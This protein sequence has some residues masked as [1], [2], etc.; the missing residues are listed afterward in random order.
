M[1]NNKE[2]CYHLPVEKIAAQISPLHLPNPIPA[3]PRLSQENRM[4]SIHL[5]NTE[6]AQVQSVSEYIQRRKRIRRTV[7]H[8]RR[9]SHRTIPRAHTHTEAYSIF[10]SR[11][12][13]KKSGKIK[14][15]EQT[16]KKMSNKKKTH[17]EEGDQERERKKEKK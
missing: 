11:R 5:G 15:K 2:C 6:L 3:R 1:K 8:T 14:K 4:Y 13:A 9:F 16:R 12:P 17:T 10:Q 7:A